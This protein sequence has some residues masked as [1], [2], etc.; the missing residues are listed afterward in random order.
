MEK[1]VKKKYE[2]P[3]VTR[4]SLDAKAVVLGFCKAESIGGP[5]YLNH[6]NP[7]LGCKSIGS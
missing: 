2:K 1:K 3:R 6:C 5:G 7:P 4:V